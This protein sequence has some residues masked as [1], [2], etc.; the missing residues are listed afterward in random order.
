[1]RQNAFAARAES[2]GHHLDPIAGF[3]EGKEWR[4]R[5]ENGLWKGRE[6]KM[7]RETG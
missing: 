1:M 7:G 6:R 2:P 5:G 3:G 4:G